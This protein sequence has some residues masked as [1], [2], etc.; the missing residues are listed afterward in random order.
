MHFCVQ[1]AGGVDEQYVDAPVLGRLNA[2]VNDRG[3]VGAGAMF[4][5]VHTGTLPPGV[6][7]LD[8]GGAKGVR[9]DQQDFLAG[10]SILCRE[11]ADGGGF[12]DT[13]YAEEDHHPWAR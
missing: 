1:P 12:T 2:V 7:L 3:G 8:G 13:V 4:D 10:R 5:D 9:G 6:K 11:L